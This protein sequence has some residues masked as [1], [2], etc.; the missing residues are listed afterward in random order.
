MVVMTET[1]NKE[2]VGL[3]GRIARGIVAVVGP[4]CEVVVHDFSDLEHSAVI[5]EG[6]ISGR[7]PGAPVPDL[8]F[9]A[10][11]LD[12]QIP[13]QLNYRIRIGNREVQSST[14]W[15]RNA[16]Q[17][18]VGALCINMDFSPLQQVQAILANFMTSPIPASN[19]VVQNSLARDLDEL[20]RNTVAHFLQTEQIPSVEQLTLHDKVRLIDQVE[21]LGLFKMRGAAQRLADILNVSR[22]SI[23]NYRAGLSGKDSSAPLSQS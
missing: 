16:E 18:V 8:D 6:N 23:Y 9:V 10:N 21:T 14:I 1:N 19:A 22:A 17:H 11:S 3:M 20:L 5:I 4:G 2:W 12:E 13:D 7:Q 15:I